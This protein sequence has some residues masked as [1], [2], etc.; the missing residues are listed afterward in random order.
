MAMYTLQSR[1]LLQIVCA[2][3]KPVGMLFWSKKWVI[4]CISICSLIKAAKFAAFSSCPV[5]PI[6]ASGEPGLEKERFDCCHLFSRQLCE[7]ISSFVVCVME[8]RRSSLLL[9]QSWLPRCCWTIS[10]RETC[11]ATLVGD[12]SDWWIVVRC[13]HAVV[14]D[15]TVL[16]FLFRCPCLDAATGEPQ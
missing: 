4:W 3:S 5:C 15:S 7:G 10:S 16:S 2:Q 12:S 13:C 11:H 9:V 6:K 8:D 1:T 14:H